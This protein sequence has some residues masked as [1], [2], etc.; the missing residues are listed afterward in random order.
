M[1]DMAKPMSCTRFPYAIVLAISAVDDLDV[2]KRMPA[3]FCS[4]LRRLIKKVS[5]KDGQQP[6]FCK[7]ET[8]AREAGCSTP[9]VYRALTRFEKEG[10]IERDWQA[11]AG[12]RGSESHIT[13]SEKLCSLL[14]LPCKPTSL[15][16]S[17]EDTPPPALPITGDRSTSYQGKALQLL[18]EGQPSPGPAAVEKEEKPPKTSIRIGGFSIPV[19]LAWLIEDQGIQPTG[20]LRLMKA[21]S[22][23]QQRLSDVVALSAAYLRKLTG[24]RLFAYLNTLISSDRDWAW[25]ARK[26]RQADADKTTEL[27][28]NQQEHSLLTSAKA[29]PFGLWFKTL[30]GGRVIHIGAASCPSGAAVFEKK[31]KTVISLSM[32]TLTPDFLK[33]IELG[34]VIPCDPMTQPV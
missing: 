33:A 3:N 18:S 6:I 29:S 8:L 25:M 34:H 24:R 28:Q 16:A 22:N 1:T 31:G 15:E 17:K 14:A 27:E 32:P 21:A 7:R 23:V 4:V 20:L 26:Q 9:T 30:K 10:L 5:A 19:E 2:F 13:F 12:L 11:C